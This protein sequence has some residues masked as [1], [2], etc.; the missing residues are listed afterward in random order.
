M[1]TRI[2]PVLHPP[3]R[4]IFDVLLRTDGDAAI[5]IGQASHAW[6]SGQLAQA[7]GNERI[8]APEPRDEVC[9][10]AGQH[11]V[12]M[13]EWDL[14][15]ALNPDTGRPQSF[16]EM[17]LPV[18][19]GLWT[20][21][22]G[23]LMTQ[24]RYAALLVSMHGTALYAQRDTSAMSPV[25]RDLVAHYLDSQR[26]FQDD[27]AVRLGADRPQLRRNQQLLWTW[28]AISLALCLHWD[29][30]TLA[31]VPAPHGELDLDLELRAHQADHFTLDPWPFAGRPV[32]VRCEGARLDGRYETEPELQRALRQAPIV[33]L[34]FT[35]TPA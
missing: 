12:G 32:R 7:W 6:V 24:S 28:D 17:P 26:A 27:L 30:L 35:L 29:P 10:A 23:R 15:P 20:A 3:R 33:T 5:A 13:A 16:L 22:P 11:D 4:M 18:H 34:E 21:A 19:V 31:E 2:A 14:R 1:K 8:P 25:E 9:L